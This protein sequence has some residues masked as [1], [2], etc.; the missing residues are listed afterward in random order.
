M[1]S[2]SINSLEM[3][4]VYLLL[5]FLAPLFRMYVLK[6]KVLQ[7]ALCDVITTINTIVE[8]K[9]TVTKIKRSSAN[10]LGFRLTIKVDIYLDE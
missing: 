1:S 8:T 7:S 6:H 5:I 2:L 3:R 4:K 9:N 10:D